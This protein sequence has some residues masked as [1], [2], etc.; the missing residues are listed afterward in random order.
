MQRKDGG[1][2]KKIMRSVKA[3]ETSP[4]VDLHATTTSADRINHLDSDTPGHFNVEVK[5][6]Y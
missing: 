1:R 3:K 5:T 6:T 4:G 2:G